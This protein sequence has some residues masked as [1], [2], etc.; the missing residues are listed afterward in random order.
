LT[1]KATIV[2]DGLPI[3]GIPIIWKGTRLQ[4]NNTLTDSSGSASNLLFVTRGTN[5]IEAGIII[6]E[7]GYFNTRK[8]ITGVPDVFT[9]QVTSNAPITITGSGNYQYGD[10]VNIEAPAQISIGGILGLLSG[11]L[12]FKE[13]T[14]FVSS[15]ERSV[16]LKI[17][18]SSPNISVNAVYTEDYFLLIITIVVLLVIIGVAVFLYM[19]RIRKNTKNK[20][21][22]ISLDIFTSLLGKNKS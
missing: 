2:I 12:N 11:K 14:G 15:S 5:I 3:E 19:T 8:I 17:T 1:V 13:W 21:S 4:S 22:K 10:N 9:L 18:G 20:N 6:G 16:T 7:G